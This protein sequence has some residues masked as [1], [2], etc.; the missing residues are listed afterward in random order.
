ME[1][2]RFCDPETQN[3]I[4]QMSADGMLDELIDHL[5]ERMQ[6]E[7]YI[8]PLRQQGETSDSQVDGEVGKVEGQVRFEVTAK[9]LDFLE[10]MALRTLLGSLANSTFGRP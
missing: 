1:S 9:S 5:I 4:D 6:Q 3:K 8:S 2:G 10:F 7:S